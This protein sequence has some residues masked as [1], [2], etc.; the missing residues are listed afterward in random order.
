MQH[1][2][3]RILYF[4]AFQDIKTLIFVLKEIKRYLFEIKDNLKERKDFQRLLFPEATW[5]PGF[6]FSL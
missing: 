5:L 1:L 3:R 4:R 2:L 6:Y